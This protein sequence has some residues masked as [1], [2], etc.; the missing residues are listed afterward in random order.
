MNGFLFSGLA[1][2]RLEFL[3]AIFNE[4]SSSWPS[5]VAELESVKDS[6]D[7]LGLVFS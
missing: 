1:E 4:N 6:V 5:K 2:Y 3:L 7:G